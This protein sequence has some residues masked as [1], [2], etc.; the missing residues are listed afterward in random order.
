MIKPEVAQRNPFLV[1]KDHIQFGAPR[2][3]NDQLK[4]HCLGDGW[5]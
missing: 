2:E 1:A 3:V 4:K 5:Q